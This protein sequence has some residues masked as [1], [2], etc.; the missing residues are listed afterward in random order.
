MILV[1]LLGGCFSFDDMLDGVWEGVIT[2]AYGDYDTVLV[3]NSNNTGSI[4]FDNDSYSVNVVNRRANRSFVGEYG[5]Y[6]SSGGQRESSRLN[7]RITV[8]CE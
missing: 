1:F 3:I 8:H 4:L 5:W 2:D 7:C 6:D